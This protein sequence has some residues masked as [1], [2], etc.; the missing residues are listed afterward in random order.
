MIC[1]PTFG[2]LIGTSLIDE[3]AAE[4]AAVAKAF[5]A[6]EFAV[7]IALHYWFLNVQLFTFLALGK[8]ELPWAGAA[9]VAL[10]WIC[11]DLDCFIESDAVD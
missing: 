10:I 1:L 2:L 8:P 5:V 7:S 3:E 9:V 11:C 6:R 4:P